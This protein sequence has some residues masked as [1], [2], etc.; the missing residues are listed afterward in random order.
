MLIFHFI[1]YFNNYIRNLINRIII[2]IPESNAFI[3]FSECL[4]NF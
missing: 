2:I 3:N 4:Q 1:I